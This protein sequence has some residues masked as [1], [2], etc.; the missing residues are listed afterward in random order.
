MKKTLIILVT[1]TIFMSCSPI[2]NLY[3][4]FGSFKKEKEKSLDDSN[5]RI[6]IDK[7]G[8]IYPDILIDHELFKKNNFNLQTVY[9]SDSA[10]LKEV[11]LSE[12]LLIDSN[13]DKNIEKLEEHFANKY[14]NLIT[15][16]GKGKKIIFLIHG[17]NSNPEKSF[18]IYNL[19]EDAIFKKLNK[20]DFQ[21]VEIYWDGLFKQNNFLNGVKIWD[22]A[23]VS[24]MYAGLGL[25]RVLSKVDNPNSYVITHSHGAAVITEALFNVRRFKN[26]YY[27]AHDDGIEFVQMQNTYLTPTAN[28]RVG[29]LAPA[30]PGNNVFEEYYQRT[31]AK[32]NKIEAL[33]NYQFINGFNKYD[34]ITTKGIFARTFGSTTL[35]CNLTESDLVENYFIAN[36]KNYKKIDFSDNDEKQSSH[37]FKDYIKNK[38]FDRF[39][40][41]LLAP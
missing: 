38:N 23:Q 16:K 13:N 5:I 21:I 8:D 7:W 39:I 24:A 27:M 30:I 12:H 6:Y 35:A 26:E 3:I 33:N 2:K 4:D 34:L 22:N 31:T 37:D 17:Y 1:T 19:L 20:N 25:R 28:F 18:E 14:A 40:I 36:P 15:H 32:G 10:I 41:Q 11:F 29:M 9:K